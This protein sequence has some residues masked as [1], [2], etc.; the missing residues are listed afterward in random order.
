MGIGGHDWKLAEL[1]SADESRAG[2][3]IN[4][5]VFKLNDFY[6]FPYTA[7]ESVSQLSSHRLPDSWRFLQFPR[8]LWM[9]RLWS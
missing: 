6:N 8:C 2:G 3:E 1:R 5:E 9:I 4:A 7:V